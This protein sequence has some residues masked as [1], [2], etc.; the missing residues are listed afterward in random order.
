[1][2]IF[3]TA[4]V[5]APG[6]LEVVA[7][8]SPEITHHQVEI[9]ISACGICGTNLHHL[10]D[11]SSIPEPKRSCPGALGHEATGRVR[12]VGEA[13][14]RL[15][16]GDLVALEPQLSAACGV[17]PPCRSGN[18]WFCEDLAP[19]AAW[20]FSERI[21]IN[22]RGAWPLPA[23]LDEA[24]GTLIEPLAIDVHALRA[25]ARANRDGGRLDGA[26]VAV[27]G[28]G[29]TGLLAVVAARHLGAAEIVA[30]AR[31][32]HQAECAARLGASGVEMDGDAVER[33]LRSFHPDLVVECVGGSA[34]TFTLAQR[35]V[36]PMGE[37]LVIGLFDQPQTVDTARAFRNETRMTF[38]VA[39]NEI[40][41]VHDFTIATEILEPR[42]GDLAPLITHRYPLD[43]IATAFGTAGDKRSGAF[44]VVVEP[45]RGS[46]R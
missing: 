11:P 29:V 43:E 25:S 39:Y 3:R 8:E 26:R 46:S 32:P 23:G 38:P 14:E 42:A 31:Y 22:Q 34:S 37:L 36:A 7:R 33:R 30:V 16:E 20:A 1:V 45:A 44:R 19:L 18:P 35:V 21:V 28:S 24:V 10:R 15:V 40:D 41:G 6:T 2:T 4:V 27:L 5:S 9:E 17:C 12:A 13:V